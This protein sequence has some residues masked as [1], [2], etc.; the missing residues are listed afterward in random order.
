MAE[1]EAI[2]KDLGRA[3]V[4]IHKIGALREAVSSAAKAAGKPVKVIW[5]REDD[6]THDKYR[7]LTAQL[8]R[9]SVA[10][11]GAVTG[12][13][14]RLVAPSFVGRTNPRALEAAKGVDA[15]VTEGAEIPYAIP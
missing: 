11:D 7:P 15:P 12:W 4:E 3:G 9:A 2:A 6:V 10:Q 1:Y 14:H 8:L 13:R 5:G